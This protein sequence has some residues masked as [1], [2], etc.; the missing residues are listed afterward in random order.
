MRK[1]VDLVIRTQDEKGRIRIYHAQDIDLSSLALK[2][3]EELVIPSKF[4][5]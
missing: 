5:N 2:D 4:K 1:L 3:K